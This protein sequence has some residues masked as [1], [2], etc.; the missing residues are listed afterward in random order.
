MTQ[1]QEMRITTSVCPAAGH[2]TSCIPV[3]APYSSG[4][5]FLDIEPGVPE[6]DEGYG[7]ADGCDQHNRKDGVAGPKGAAR[8]YHDPRFHSGTPSPMAEA[9]TSQERCGENCTF[10]IHG[11]ARVGIAECGR[12]LIHVRCG[13]QTPICGACRVPVGKLNTAVFELCN[14][15]K[16]RRKGGVICPSCVEFLT[17]R[18]EKHLGMMGKMPTSSIVLWMRANGG[19]RDAANSVVVDIAVEKLLAA[20][21]SG[22]VGREIEGGGGFEHF[23]EALNRMAGK[24]QSAT[25]YAVLTS[26]DPSLP[27]EAESALRIFVAERRRYW[28]EVP[29]SRAVVSL[30]VR[31]GM[32]PVS[33]I[34]QDAQA[35]CDPSRLIAIDQE[36]AEALQRLKEEGKLHTFGRFV[37]YYENTVSP[38]TSRESKKRVKRWNRAVRRLREKRE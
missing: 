23:T 19:L 25:P 29:G 31:R 37:F 27:P 13:A 3:G 28:Q 34:V 1:V 6:R 16:C 35:L 32:P 17:G 5:L 21:G 18:F 36:N 12:C 26:L 8:K 38:K 10:H 9:Y 14:V 2:E 24:I 15:G 11:D 4:F 7:E 33:E 30:G 22:F 20:V